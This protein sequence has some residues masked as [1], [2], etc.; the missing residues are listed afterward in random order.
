MTL[1]SFANFVIHPIK[2]FFSKSVGL[3]FLKTIE[4]L[5]YKGK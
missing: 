2:R 1:S 4:K 5:K 3:N